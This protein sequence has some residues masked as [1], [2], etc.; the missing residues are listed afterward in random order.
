[1]PAVA[2]AQ[3]DQRWTAWQDHLKKSV[4]FPLSW[5]RASQALWVA[6]QCLHHLVALPLQHLSCLLHECYATSRCDAADVESCLKSY[7]LLDCVYI[8]DDL[9]T[10][11]FL[12]S[13]IWSVSD[14]GAR[15]SPSLPGSVQHLLPSPHFLAVYSS[16]E[17]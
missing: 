17:P 12:A 8:V 11:F 3:I 13:L 9:L 5:Q 4:Q 1:V 7:Y 2:A 6:K 14:Y 16:Q 10:C 15:Q